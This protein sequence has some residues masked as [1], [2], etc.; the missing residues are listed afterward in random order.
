M[1]NRKIS[2]YNQVASRL[3]HGWNMTALLLQQWQGDKRQAKK[4]SSLADS[5]RQPLLTIAHGS[6]KAPSFGL[7]DVIAA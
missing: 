3:T 1:E 5:N 4:R 7:S 2:S 6:I